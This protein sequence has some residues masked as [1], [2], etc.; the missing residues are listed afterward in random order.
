MPLQWFEQPLAARPDFAG[1]EPQS[2]ND[3]LLRQ[4]AEKARRQLE[5]AETELLMEFRNPPGDRARAADNRHLPQSSLRLEFLLGRDS[6][7]YL[8]AAAA[9][10]RD[11]PFG[12]R[13]GGLPGSRVAVADNNEAA[14]Q[15]LRYI[16]ARIPEGCD[17]ATDAVHRLLAALEQGEAALADLG[18]GFLAIGRDIDRRMRPL[19]AFRL[20]R[21]GARADYDLRLARNSGPAA[22]SM[23]RMRPSD[24]RNRGLAGC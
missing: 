13:Q 1:E 4:I 11:Q 2:P 22:R 10:A 24:P 12:R 15:H 23:T 7:L 14:D 21:L 9:V 19:D 5:I 8:L 18:G 16:A 20:D 3:V 6:P 17:A